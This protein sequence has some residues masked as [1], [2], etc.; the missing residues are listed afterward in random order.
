LLRHFDL[1]GALIDDFQK[2]VTQCFV[3]FHRAPDDPAG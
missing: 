2:P 1:Q 3:D